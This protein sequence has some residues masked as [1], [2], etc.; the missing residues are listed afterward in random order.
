[1]E[2]VEIADENN[3]KDDANIPEGSDDEGGG[4]DPG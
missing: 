2:S 4:N 1:V 3:K